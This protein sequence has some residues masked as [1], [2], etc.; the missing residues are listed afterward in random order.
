MSINI[1]LDNLSEALPSDLPPDQRAK[2]QTLFLKKLSADAHAFFGGKMQ[3]L[4]KCGLWGFNWF[5]V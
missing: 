5:N 2:A 1:S 4:P 3:T